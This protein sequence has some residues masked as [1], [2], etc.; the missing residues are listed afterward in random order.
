MSKTEIKPQ[1]SEFAGERIAKVLA[2]AGICSRRDAER[3]IAEGLVQVDGE[4]ILSPAL[5]VTQ[6]QTIHVN[7]KLVPRAEPTRVWRYHKPAGQVT[8]HKDPEGRPTV[9]DALSKDMPRVISVGRL[10]YNT[11]GLL[12]LTNDGELARR[13]ELPKTAWLRKYRVRV[14]GKVTQEDLLKFED[15]TTID[16]VKYGPV[17]ATLDR[18]QRG[19]A[20]ITMGLREGKNREVRRLLESIGLKVNRLIRI[21]Y[22]PFQLGNLEAG[23]VEEVNPKTLDEQLGLKPSKKPTWAKAKKRA[24]AKNKTS[25]KKAKPDANRRRDS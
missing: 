3:M 17:Q 1:S 8:T 12:L 6:N 20:W 4:Q 18:V 13:L 2:R 22:G 7:G 11:E 15:G 23:E 21:S 16:G 24:G 14:F 9:F 25:K 19:N 5:N 10:D